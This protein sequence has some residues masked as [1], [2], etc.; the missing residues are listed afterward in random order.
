MSSSRNGS[1]PLS[2]ARQTTSS[3]VTQKRAG[4]R[5]LRSSVAAIWRPSVKATAAGP[6]HG[7]ISAAW[8]S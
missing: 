2:E 3:R 8:Y 6:S 1:T 4:L 5:P 7:S